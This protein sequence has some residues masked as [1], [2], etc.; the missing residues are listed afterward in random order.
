MAEIEHFVDPLDK[1]HP[2]FADVSSLELTLFSSDDQLGSGRTQLLSVGD[3]VSRGMINNETLA[4]F[5][6]RTQ[7]FLTRA[8]VDPRR[9]RFRQHLRTEM[10]HYAS[11]CWDA[12]IHT[13][14]GWVECVG[15]ADRACYDLQ[16]HSDKTG[17]GMTAAQALDEPITVEFVE[18]VPDKKKI[19]PKYR[20]DQ[21]K[22][23]TFLEDLQTEGG[24]KLAA[25]RAQLE[26]D[27]VATLGETGLTI[28][29]DLVTFNLTRK[30]TY[31][32][33]F[34][35]S[36]IEPS[37]GMGRILYA[38]MEHSYSQRKEDEQRNVMSFKPVVAP[39]K[40]G[41]FSLEHSNTMMNNLTS[42]LARELTEEGVAVRTDAS[43]NNIGR[44]YARCD[45]L[46]CPFAITIDN[47]TLTMQLVTLRERDSCA[48]VAVPIT[49]VVR[50]V[51]ELSRERISWSEVMNIYP[52]VNTGAA[53]DEASS[54]TT[55][56]ATDGSASAS[57]SSSSSVVS[58]EKS[59][60]AY[61]SRPKQ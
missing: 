23:L 55:A 11:D 19:G 1:S 9:L 41:I 57:S 48:Q 14:Y 56:G 13:S 46:G 2:R 47:D 54:T 59:S 37:F 3:A 27:G 10:A 16:V 53:A 40:C 43:S 17:V 18:V 42:R 15:H 7:M 51:E 28:T 49:K 50:L 4:Y 21:K 52:L 5:M 39:Y 32:R 22:V 60:R 44:R 8:G 61:F 25:F 58:V 29:K 45:E 6:A 30:T 34:T 20:G 38:I 24:D 31:E 26:T 33:R 36:V 35:P 12:E